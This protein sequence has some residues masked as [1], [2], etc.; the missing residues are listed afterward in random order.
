[1]YS[2]VISLVMCVLFIIHLIFNTGYLSYPMIDFFQ[3]FFF[4]L[5]FSTD[6]PPTLNY[7]FL[8][9]KYSHFLFL[10]QIFNKSL[11]T[12]TTSNTPLKFGIIVGDIDF[13]SNTGHDFLIIFVIVGLVI[14][15]KLVDFWCWC[16]DQS[17][18]KPNKIY[19]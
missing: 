5:F 19:N 18:N 1:M 16:L 2:K 8:G 9:Y 13:F 17:E 14:L 7:F 11:P 10:P 12:I 4:F 15:V 6:F 3:L